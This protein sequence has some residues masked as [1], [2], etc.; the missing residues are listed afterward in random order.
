MAVEISNK[1]IQLQD[2]DSYGSKGRAG[3][4]IDTYGR[5]N[6]QKCSFV[7]RWVDKGLANAKLLILTERQ[8]K[9][10]LVDFKAHQ[11]T[12]NRRSEALQKS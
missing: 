6:N 10:S 12:L 11:E 7:D 2:S 1:D 4:L 8:L 9:D 3:H 5:H